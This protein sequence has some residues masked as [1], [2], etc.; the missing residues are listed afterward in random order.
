MLPKGILGLR[1][2]ERMC[3]LAGIVLKSKVFVS[4]RSAPSISYGRLQ[5][6]LNKILYPILNGI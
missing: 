6:I 4:D 1:R 2:T 3:I 5:N